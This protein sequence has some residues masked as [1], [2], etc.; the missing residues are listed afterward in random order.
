MKTARLLLCVIAAT[1]LILMPDTAFC[2][3]RRPKPAALLTRITL[4]SP[5]DGSTLYSP[6]T[7][8]WTADGDG[9]IFAVELSASPNFRTYWSTFKN[10]QEKIY[11]TSWTVPSGLWGQINAGTRLYWRVRG[12]DIYEN[13]GVVITSGQVWSAVMQTPKGRDYREDMRRFVEG[14][15]AYAKGIRPGFNVIPQNGHE[16]LTVNGAATGPVAQAY[17]DAIDGV[18]REDLF[19]GYSADNIPTPPTERN[20]MIGF[21]NV[22]ENNGVQ[23]FV[24]DYCRTPAYVDDSYNQS[25]SRGYT[26]FA[27]SHRE[28]DNIP[29]YPA[30]PFHLNS[31]N[32]VSLADAKNFLYILNPGAFL[33]KQLF[34]NAIHDTDYDLFIIDLFYND[35][36]LTPAEVASLKTKA[37]G[38]SRLVIAYMSIGEAE[39]YRYYWQPSWATNPPYWLAGENPAWPGNYKVHYWDPAWQAIIYGNNDS[40]LKKILDAGFDGVYLDI[41]DAYEYF[42]S[43]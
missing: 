36:E 29:T 32:V 31:A 3:V 41:I 14:I 20:Y 26:S 15:S 13:P 35:I 43:R 24:T 16:L 25:G 10:L 34:L 6:P 12:M 9:N 33:T 23:A 37:H 1:V 17:V 7:F 30:S 4:V 40:Y 19:Y 11:G 5:V 27:A 18:G 42:E 28:L 2:G 38:G 22:A 8:N 21:M 39:D